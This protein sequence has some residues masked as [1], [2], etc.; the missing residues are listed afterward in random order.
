MRV[1]VLQHT[2]NEGP[3]A[4]AAWCK[5]R[6]HEMFVYHPYQ[7]NKLP[8]A[9]ECDMLVILGG[10]MSPNDD[11]DW[12]KQE[13][14]LVKELMD[15]NKPIYGACFG[16]QLLAQTLGAKVLTAPHKEVGWAPVYLKSKFLK[17]LPEKMTVLHWHQDMFEIPRDAE[18]LFSSDLVE[19]Q[20][21]LYHQNVLGLQFHFE[22][23]ADNVREMV[24]NDGDYALEN[25]ALKQTP[26]DI[27]SQ[28]VP[29][30]NKTI[31]YQLLDFIAK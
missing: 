25:N 7:F 24:V 20:G 27:L 6:G 31:I 3:G 16:A 5:A 23:L 11:F 29:A 15:E 9:D 2:P 4:I 8:K 26:A 18:L 17:D 10:P 28:N 13:K 30:E 1:N 19:N 12:I 22:P 14:A 21:F